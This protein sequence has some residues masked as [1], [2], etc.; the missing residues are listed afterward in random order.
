MRKP[1]NQKNR[2]NPGTVVIPL[3]EIVV[4][5]ESRTKFQVDRATGD[6]LL[7]AMKDENHAHAIGLTVKS[8]TR[9]QE[10]TGESLYKNG[11][12]V[13]CRL[14]EP[15]DDGY[16]ICAEVVQR[17]KDRLHMKKKGGS[18]PRTNRSRISLTSKTI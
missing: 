2:R 4:Y 5:P 18:L 16:V 14:R 3:F 17:V 13:P 12:P 15:A 11:K 1:C 6:L 8:G 7:E 10:L 9:P